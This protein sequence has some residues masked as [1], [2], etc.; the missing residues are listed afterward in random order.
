MND[1][2]NKYKIKI[3]F[4]E[5]I[6]R[7]TKKSLPWFQ[8]RDSRN[9][10]QAAYIHNANLR[11]PPSPY[12]STV[13]PPLPHSPCFCYSV[14]PPPRI[15]QTVFYLRIFA[16]IAFLLTFLHGLLFCKLKTQVS[17]QI[18]PFYV[19]LLSTEPKVPSNSLSSH[20]PLASSQHFSLL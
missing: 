20:L 16:L 3:S 19:C 2:L 5:C 14:L 8:V 18:S 4:H 13:Q 17:G 1:F 7:Y 12:H 6:Q 11:D 10:V 9:K 15:F